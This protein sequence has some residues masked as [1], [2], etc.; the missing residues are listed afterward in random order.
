MVDWRDDLSWSAKV[1][2][3]LVWP[4]LEVQIGGRL[5]IVETST[6]IDMA[7]ALDVKAGIDAWH[8]LDGYG[9]RGIA[10][11]VQICPPIYK[12]YNTFTVRKSRDS[13]TETEYTKRLRAIRTNDGWL[14]PHL[15][16]QAYVTSEQEGQLLSFAVAQTKSLIEHIESLGNHAVTKR[17]SNAEFYIV[18]FKDIAIFSYLQPLS[19]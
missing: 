12:P 7:T 9:V 18:P 5:I 11:R 6:K 14:Y 2:V 17:T 8:V 3:G 4:I 10:S 1:F 15:T 16:V 19:F 13:G